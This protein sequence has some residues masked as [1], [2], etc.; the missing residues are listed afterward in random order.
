MKLEYLLPLVIVPALWLAM[1]VMRINLARDRIVR[2]LHRDHPDV[3]KSIAEPTGW[4]WSSPGRIAVPWGMLSVPV[5][6][7]PWLGAAPELRADVQLVRSLRRRAVLVALPLFAFCV[8]AF[9]VI[10]SML[11][12]P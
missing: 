9:A 5:H 11:R 7:P 8:V 1:L 10:A 3:W 6:D 2:S 12:H 4:L